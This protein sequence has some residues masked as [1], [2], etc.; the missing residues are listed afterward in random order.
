MQSL[1]QYTPYPYVHLLFGS[2]TRRPLR[3][4]VEALFRDEA[5]AGEPVKVRAGVNVGVDT[6]QDPHR[7]RDAAGRRADARILC[8]R[9]GYGQRCDGIALGLSRGVSIFEGWLHGE[10]LFAFWSRSVVSL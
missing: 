3:S 7:R 4:R 1:L 5:A 10:L 2:G 8:N 9:I 6:V